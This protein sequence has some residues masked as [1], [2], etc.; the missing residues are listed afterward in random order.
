ML[1]SHIV[2]MIQMVLDIV[3]S[4][5]ETLVT[6]GALAMPPAT[7]EMTAV[8]MHRHFACVSE[9]QLANDYNKGGVGDKFR[10]TMYLD[11]IALY[12]YVCMT[13]FQF[14]PLSFPSKLILQL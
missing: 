2:V 3:T 10:R 7:T 12:F 6:T 5:S 13:Q 4:T 8:K 14:S 9:W 11:L 1:A